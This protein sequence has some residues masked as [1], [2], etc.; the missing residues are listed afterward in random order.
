[1]STTD[2]K[3]LSNKNYEIKEADKFKAEITEI[4]ASYINLYENCDKIQTS[5]CKKVIK[6]PESTYRAFRD[7]PIK[8]GIKSKSIRRYYKIYMLKEEH[9]KE[10]YCD[11]FEDDIDAFI[12]DIDPNECR[13]RL[14]EFLEKHP[15]KQEDS[16]ECEESV[17]EEQ[18]P[19]EELQ[20]EL[21]E[22]VENCMKYL[23]DVLGEYFEFELDSY[24][25]GQYITVKY[26]E[27]VAGVVV[28]DKII[29]IISCDSMEKEME[30]IKNTIDRTNIYL[31]IHEAEEMRIT[32]SSFQIYVREN[33]RFLK[34]TVMELIKPEEIRLISNPD[35]VKWKNLFKPIVKV[36][37][38][39]FKPNYLAYMSL[40]KN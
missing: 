8:D 24:K 13:K 5:F 15:P 18:G 11:F 21:P 25:F 7:K 35:K 16:V 12:K 19:E 23:N 3:I 26:K 39:E 31:L 30:A 9:T 22:I 34:V 40:K 29:N 37:K 32:E 2:E 20:N 6:M 10:G 36:V 1:M 33:E 17:I 28:K 4:V 38:S 14:N 27:K